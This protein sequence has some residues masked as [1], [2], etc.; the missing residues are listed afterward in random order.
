L[1]IRQFL[2]NK[3]IIRDKFL[4]KEPDLGTKYQMNRFTLAFPGSAE[5][6]FQKEH[7]AKTVRQ[8]RIAVI[9]GILFYGFFGLLDAWIFPETKHTLW[10]IRYAIVIPYFILVFLFSY[11]KTFER[12][13][14][15][16]VSSAVLMAGLGIIAMIVVAPSP[17]NSYYYAGLLL[18]F[19][20]GYTF[21]MIR[22]IWATA[23][24]WLIV[25]AYEVAAVWLSDTPILV[26][27]SNNFFFLAG[28]LFG[29]FSC[30]SIEFASRRD[31][32]SAQLLEI[33]KEKVET[34]NQGLE[35][36]VEAR[37]RQLVTVND[38]LRNEIRER[39]E[40]EERFRTLFERSKDAVFISTSDGDI[41][42]LNP[43]G[44]EL[45]GYSS[46]EEIAGI[47]IAQDLYLNPRERENFLRDMEER[48]HVKDY[49]IKLK[50]KDGTIITVLETSTAVKNDEGKIVGYQGIIRDITEQKELERQ[51]FQSEK[52]KT[53]GLLAGGIAHDL[54]NVLAPILMS[55]QVLQQ[56]MKDE[57]VK[58][59]LNILEK[60]AKRG[61]DIV[62]QVLAFARG[63][64][65]EMGPLQVKH[66]LKDTVEMISETFP[67]SVGLKADIP[68][69]LWTIQGDA[70]KLQQ[71]LMNLC[72]NARDA[73]PTGGTLTLSAR[74][75]QLDKLSLMLDNVHT[76]GPYVV[77]EVADTG[78]GMSPDTV[79]QI[80]KP[81]FTTKEIGKGTGLG[82]EVVKSIID[83]HKGFVT[84]ASELDAGSVFRVYL[85][86]TL[87][88]GESEAVVHRPVLPM[89]HGELILVV[90]DEAAIREITKEVLESSGFRVLAAPGGPEAVALLAA[91][92]GDVKVVVTDMMM[93]IMDGRTTIVALRNIDPAIRV[94]VSSG[95]ISERE[96][97]EIRALDIVDFLTKPF[98]AQMLLDVLAQAIAE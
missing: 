91:N 78:S 76:P 87:D 93:P 30:Y 43:A 8:V 37:T 2:F 35:L 67:K 17:Q 80:F 58:T 49:E 84:V 26:L 42:D 54:N 48:Y 15:L 3:K 16:T 97:E 89:G 38:E 71:V 41:L 10:A 27:F 39:Q 61:G 1:L 92:K 88:E 62:R 68:K 73:M 53:I 45:F 65:G 25:I 12:Y 11:F 13:K 24:G 29:M 52:M 33:E 70:T 66:L 59:L 82:L 72:V 19:I 98:T 83:L 85:P 28:N 94:I 32:V 5:Q 56:K 55:V 47:N 96:E 6:E 77:L 44:I 86:A 51:L 4:A 22:F 74:N 57:K 7:H 14:N 81:F 46:F 79:E 75:E 64:G 60:N 36:R 21:V 31:F 69:D 50:R 20:Y 34:L 63:T 40:A 23:T 90:D 9:L 95:A 18:V